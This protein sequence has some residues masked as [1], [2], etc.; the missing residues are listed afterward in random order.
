MIRKYVRKVVHWTEKKNRQHSLVPTTPFIT[1][2]KFPWAPLIEARWEEI[3]SELDT[4]LTYRN[5]LP[6]FQE[7]SREQ[8]ALTQDDQWKTFIF[9]GYGFSSADNLGRCPKT[10]EALARIP[11]L[12]T[13]FFSV[14]GPGKRVPVHRGPYNGVLRYHLALKIPEPA[15]ACGIEVGGETRHWREGGGM[16]FDDTYP[17]AAWNETGEDRVVLFLDIVRPVRFPYNIA[18][19]IVLWTISRSP[20][21]KSAQRNQQAWEERFQRLRAGQA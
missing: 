17:H 20:F 7:I 12:T 14:F 3:R 5:D 11:G 4:V 19:R 2:E 8:R 9:H 6:N 15:D 21:I 1:G 18:N 13:A 16:F 10:A